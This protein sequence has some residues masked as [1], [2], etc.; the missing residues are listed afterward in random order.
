MGMPQDSGTV[1][2]VF[3]CGLHRSGTTILAREIGRLKGCTAFENTG[4]EMDEGQFLQDVYPP[5][6]AYGSTGRF[7]FAPQAHLTES[8]PLLTLRNA[9]RLRQ[10]WQTYW[11]E[12]KKIRVEKTPGNLLMTRFLQA[13]FGN[14]YFIV[15]KRHPVVVS[16]A[17]QKWSRTSLHS[18]FRHWLRC[19]AIFDEDKKHLAH[20]YELKYEDY[21][22]DPAA[23]LEE[24]AA[25]LGVTA[26]SCPVNETGKDFNRRYLER[27]GE[28]LQK[29]P[30]RAY[31]RQIASMYE[32]QFAAYGYSL[33]APFGGRVFTLGRDTAL[34]RAF[35]APVRLS[36]DL[37]TALWRGWEPL[38][39][40]ARRRWRQLR[41]V[42]SPRPGTIPR[43]ANIT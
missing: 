40:S 12:S 10:C 31:Y 43:S 38:E 34:R 36:A 17:T 20:L 13:V 25:F 37:C 39:S 32:E 33:A 8:S 26:P 3:V 35:G 9:S 19:H 16:L 11:D 23:R 1:R 24:I 4:A 27:W 41:G 18:L 21:V 14:A 42:A 6:T 2:H 22:R 15:I 28:M 30:Y 7:G 29:S 5:D